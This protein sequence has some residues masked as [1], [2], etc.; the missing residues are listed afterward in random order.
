MHRRGRSAVREPPPPGEVDSP[1][2]MPAARSLVAAG[3]VVSPPL[4]SWQDP[5][6]A[7][8][9]RPIPSTGRGHAFRIRTTTPVAAYTVSPWEQSTPTSHMSATMLLPRTYGTRAT[10]PP[11]R[12]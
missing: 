7:T 6:D 11:H 1:C 8:L 10:W 9:V 4:T 5:F 2:P 12:G 3:E